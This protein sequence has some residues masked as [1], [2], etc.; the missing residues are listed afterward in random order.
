[1][2]ELRERFLKVYANLPLPMRDEIILMLD[3]RLKAGGVD[4][5]SPITW[6]VAYLEV[7][8][9][10]ELSEKILEELGGLGLI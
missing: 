2:D 8:Q 7:Q 5:K 10:T 6:N 3:G 4:I 9:N 1:M